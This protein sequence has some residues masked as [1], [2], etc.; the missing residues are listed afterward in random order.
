VVLRFSLPKAGVVTLDAFDPAGRRVASFIDHEL[1]PAGRQKLTVQTAGWGAGL[2]FVR[3]E[4]A[5]QSIRRKMV[6]VI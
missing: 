5:G 2:Y 1:R 4:V 3:L 6:I